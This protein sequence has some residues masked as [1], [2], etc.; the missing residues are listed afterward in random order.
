MKK[1]LSPTFFAL[2]GNTGIST[3]PH[4]HYEVIV[5]GQHR[6]PTLADDVADRVAPL[7][8]TSVE[9]VG[10]RRDGARKVAHVAHYIVFTSL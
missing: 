4:L 1:L 2:V 3:G 10:D 9:G 8:E 7:A 6:D 5:R